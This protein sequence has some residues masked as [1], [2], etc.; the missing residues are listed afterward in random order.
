MSALAVAAKRSLVHRIKKML[1]PVARLVSRSSSSPK[2]SRA[3]PAPTEADLDNLANEAL[4]QKRVLAENAANEARVRVMFLAAPST[5]P[6]A[7]VAAASSCC[8]RADADLWVTATISRCQRA[9]QQR[10]L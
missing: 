1:K 7:A 3:P 8:A 6:A 5:A 4:E 2:P 9:E 10:P